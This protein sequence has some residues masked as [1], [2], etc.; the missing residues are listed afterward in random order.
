MG[1]T[2]VRLEL[3]ETSDRLEYLPYLVMADESESVVKEYIAEGQMFAIVG[4]SGSVIGVALFVEESKGVIELKNIALDPQFRRLGL[5]KQVINQAFEIFREQGLRK[6]MVG[7]ANSSIANLA[8]YQKAGF[9]MVEIRKDFFSKY[10]EPIFE[11][12]IQAVDMVMFERVLDE[13]CSC[14]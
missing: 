12:G 6:M 14:S 3:V 9:R 10:P 8:F 2:S 7:T 5:G 11:D 1:E 4:D 13:S